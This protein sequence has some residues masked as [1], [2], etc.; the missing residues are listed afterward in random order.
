MLLKL[1]KTSLYTSFFAVVVVMASTFFPFIGGKY[2]FFRFFVE[3]ALAFLLLW[4][5]FEAPRGEV[6]RRVM[7][8]WKQPLVIAV[9]IFVLVYLLATAF[10]YDSSAAFW[11]NY[12]RG[13]GGFQM[14]HYYLFFLLLLTVF[15]EW[16]DWR[17]ALRV[18]LA[19]ASLM[20]LYGVTAQLLP[21]G[22]G[23]F[24]FV[25]PYQQANPPT[26]VWELL[27]IARFQGSLGNPAYVAPYLI[28][29]IFFT[30]YLWLERRATA[31]G[32]IRDALYGALVLAFIFFFFLS[33]TRGAFLGLAAAIVAAFGYLIAAARSRIRMLALW[34]LIAIFLVGGAL[35]ALKDNSFVQRLPGSRMFDISFSGD[36]AQTRFWTWG[37]A[38]KGFR[39]R[40]ILGWGP[41][42]FSTV[43][44]KYFDARHFVPGKNTETWFDRAHSV[45][46]G[47]LTETGILGL[48]SYLAIFFV[49]YRQFFKKAYANL[50]EEK[51]RQKTHATLRDSIGI[52]ALFFAMPIGY[53]VQGAAL[54]DV[55]PIYLNLFFFFALSS[56]IFHEHTT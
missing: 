43:F 36:T 13:E 10:A 45:F 25:T 2:F 7:R 3:L 34:G 6:E 27:T 17:R 38:L 39:E 21:G 33:Q 28:F 42:N 5:G 47:Y 40:P 56:F 41:E 54:F 4:W 51:S 19:A 44:D 46:F 23:I 37:S 52:R 20:I 9:S 30:F 31:K 35:F 48:A 24:L 29:S 53:L 50:R 1:S 32:W 18:S 16:S 11:S 49:F 14:L 26:A 8:L 15:T 55:L 22:Q 12:E